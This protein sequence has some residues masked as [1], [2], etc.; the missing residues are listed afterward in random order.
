MQLHQ[1]HL[2]KGAHKRRKMKGRGSSSGHG[3][4]SGRGSKGQKSRTGRKFWL[5][6]EG[7]QTPLIRRFPKRGFRNPRK[8]DFQIVNLE[9]LDRF[10][11]NFTITPEILEK[12]GLIK[13]RNLP[14]KILGNGEINKS[15]KISAHRFSKSAK[16]K[17]ARL[18]GEFKL[19]I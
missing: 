16:E 3:K 17:I 14:V 7:G 9:N 5:G 18:G 11:E 10:P 12:E 6:F 4:T 15:F 13:D 2:P 1:L 8:R 19:L